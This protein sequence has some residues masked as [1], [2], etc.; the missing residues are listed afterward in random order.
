MTPEES[1][2]YR[3]ALAATVYGQ[4]DE[5]H[6]NGTDPYAHLPHTADTADD[7]PDGDRKSW[8]PKMVRGAAYV[9]D[10]PTGVPAIWGEGHRVLW[11]EGEA[12]MITGPQGVGKTT[13]ISQVLAGLLGLRITPVLGLPVT[14]PQRVLYL[15][16]DRPRQIARALRRSFTEED[17]G[18]LDERLIV[19][20]GPPPQD[21]AANPGLLLNLAEDADAD[22]VIVDS[23]KDAALGL[24][25]DEVAAAYNRARQAVLNSGRNMAEL[26]HVTKRR[27]DD[28]PMTIADV[29]G[30][31]WLTSGA[32]SVIL[33]DGQPGDPIVSFRHLKQPAD[34]IGP[35]R[36]L[37]DQDAGVMTIEHQIDLVDLVR[38]AGV[39]G[40]TAR[41]A[42]TAITDKQNPSRSDTEK[43]RRQLDRL[44]AAGLL[45][46]REGEKGGS[47]G[48]RAATWFLAQSDHG[49][50]RNSVN[51]QVRTDHGLFDPPT[52]HAPITPI[53]ETG[54]TAG[55]SDHGTDHT[56]HAGTDHV[57]PP[58]F[59]GRGNV[60]VGDDPETGE[61]DA[62]GADGAS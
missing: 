60:S 19:W 3:A 47:S 15:A 30:S 32:G 55:Q 24:S 56:D 61:D 36:L 41:A 11:A 10:Q 31:T 50:S 1:S 13:L 20:K 44:C 53:T 21:V 35:F 22:I 2:E 12:L 38:A 54:K 48:G 29:Y 4:P 62:A 37:H 52:D 59:I 16:M 7:A 58:P 26:H 23:L 9:L 40:M 8:V 18:I 57:F 27:S 34:E 14:A 33:L 6:H 39:F 45:Y 17:R 46:R 25:K 28:A 51:P 42:A 49:R 5:P 43:A